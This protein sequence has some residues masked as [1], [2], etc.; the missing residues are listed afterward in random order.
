MA[1]G[2]TDPLLLSRG[3]DVS[4]RTLHLSEHAALPSARY[5]EKDTMRLWKTVAQGVKADTGKAFGG[6]WA[7]RVVLQPAPADWYE[8]FENHFRSDRTPGV[9]EASP[10]GWGFPV[11]RTD[12]PT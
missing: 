5:S 2:R 11:H 4:V 10:A 3:Q 9:Q 6:A 12:P 8:P 7:V 1:P